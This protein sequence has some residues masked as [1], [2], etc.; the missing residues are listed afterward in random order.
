[1]TKMG[2]LGEALRTLAHPDRRKMMRELKT[3]AEAEVEAHDGDVR[4]AL[5]HRHL[6]DLSDAGYLDYEQ[7]G[8]QFTIRR[9]DN[10]QEAAD[11][12]DAVGEC[13]LPSENA[14]VAII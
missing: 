11:L 1:M 6:P 13:D 9:G 7:S 2:I 8:Y 3:H 10:W 12:L 14:E 5:V 4:L